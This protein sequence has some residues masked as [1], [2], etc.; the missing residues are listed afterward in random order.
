MRAFT[1]I[2]TDPQD[3]MFWQYFLCQADDADHAGEQCFN[4]YPE[5][6]VLLINEGHDAKAKL[7]KD[8][9]HE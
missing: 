1:V 4:A 5:C 2:Y 7:W 8:W 9:N 3:G 6:S